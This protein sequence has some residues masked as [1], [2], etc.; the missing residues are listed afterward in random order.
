MDCREDV[1]DKYQHLGSKIFTK[2]E[3]IELGKPLTTKKK[4]TYD[5]EGD[6]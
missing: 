2:E 4:Y 6:P 1:A 3:N 5:V